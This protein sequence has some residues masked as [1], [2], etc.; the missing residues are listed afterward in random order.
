MM[1]FNI[2]SIESYRYDEHNVHVFTILHITYTYCTLPCVNVNVYGYFVFGG[3]TLDVGCSKKKN[4]VILSHGPFY[5][6]LQSYRDA[7]IRS[8]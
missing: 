4:L 7:V 8:P 5:V 1:L 2:I 6:M 3:P